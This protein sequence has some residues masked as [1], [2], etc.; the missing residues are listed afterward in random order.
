M[1]EE[2]EEREKTGWILYTGMALAP[3]E[4]TPMTTPT[5]PMTTQ[6]SAVREEAW[7]RQMTQSITTLVLVVGIGFIMLTTVMVLVCFMQWRWGHRVQKFNHRELI[8]RERKRMNRRVE[9][10][11][12]VGLEPSPFQKAA[13]GFKFRTLYHLMD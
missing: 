13:I 1:S 9:R 12:L 2:R 4:A 6:P 5:T 11:D 3:T 8:E 10:S 7:G